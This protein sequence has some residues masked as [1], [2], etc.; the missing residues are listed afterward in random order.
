MDTTAGAESAW[1]STGDTAIGG[2]STNPQNDEKAGSHTSSAGEAVNTE[3]VSPPDMFYVATVLGSQP[4]LAGQ[5][6]LISAGTAWKNPGRNG[7]GEDFDIN[8]PEHRQL[9][10]DSGGFQATAHFGARYP[11]DD[12]DL[13]VW[14]EDVGADYVAGMDFTCEEASVLESEV[15]AAN[16]DEIPS[17]DDRIERTIDK[18]VEQYTLYT[19]LRDHEEGWSFEFIPVVQGRSVAQYRYC[20]ERLKAAGLASEYMAIGSVCKRSDTDEIFEVLKACRDVLPATEFHLFGATRRIWKDPRAFGTFRSADT[21][22][23]GVSHPSDGWPEDNQEKAEAFAFFDADIQRVRESMDEQTTIGGQADEQRERAS[24]LPGNDM[25]GTCTF[26]GSTIPTYGISFSPDCTACQR[27][28]RRRTTYIQ[29]RVEREVASTA[30]TKRGE[31]SG[32][33][34]NSLGDYV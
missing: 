34:Q 2:S 20:A 17:V 33:T 14:A 5:N 32:Q 1:Y 11:Y 16:A 13:F 30:S 12:T 21:H 28:K 26:C 9:M 23:W 10:V 3:G 31:A 22:A 8:I 25:A 18:Q 15:E 6:I 19:E 24:R 29:S 27:V 4:W 7:A